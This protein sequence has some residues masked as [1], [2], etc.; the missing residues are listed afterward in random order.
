MY[1]KKIVPIFG[2]YVKVHP[3][4]M[5]HPPENNPGCTLASSINFSFTCGVAC[6]I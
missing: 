5:M 2:V 4:E 3:P 6:F 1:F